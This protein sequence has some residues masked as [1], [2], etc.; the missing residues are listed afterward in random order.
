MSYASAKVVSEG[1]FESLVTAQ[2]KNKA[3][4]EQIISL[5]KKIDNVQDV[6]RNN[7]S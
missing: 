3:E 4:E 6:I 7:L 2:I 5:I 1:K